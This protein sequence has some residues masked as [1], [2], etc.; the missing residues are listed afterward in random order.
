MTQHPERFAAA[1]PEVGVLDMLRYHRFTIGR[2]WV[3]E[4]GCSD[5][6]EQFAWLYAYSPLHRV[7]AG[8]KYPA[9]LV[10]TGDHDDRVLPG[11]SYK[12]AAA[13]QAAQGGTAPVLL[14]IDTATGHG[15]G[16]PVQKLIDE[17]ADRWA[18]LAAALGD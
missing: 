8:T 9:T 12:F 16:K 13:L 7:R 18:F 2:A 6:A 14:R 15:A 3:P 5:D 10:M 17:A 11:H 1:I 4:Y